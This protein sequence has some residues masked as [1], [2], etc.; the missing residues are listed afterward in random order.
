[1][2]EET[3]LLLQGKH[4]VETIMHA[5]SIS[6]Q[7]AINLVSK[8]KKEG[9]ATTSGGGRQKR[10]YTITPYRQVKQER[11]GTFD[12][13]NRY[14]KIKLVPQFRHVPHSK[15]REEDALID[16]V[17]TRSF[18]TV[19]ASL[20]LFRHIKDWSYLHKLAKESMLEAETGML[21]DIARKTILTKRMPEKMYKALLKKRPRKKRLLTQSESDDFKEISKKWN[22]WVPFSKK[23]ME[24]IK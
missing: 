20:A 13:I 9:Y 15:Y 6:M 7:A 23:D 11:P 21:Y 17:K 22:I 14:S 4:T 3:L 8:L 10:I 12:I 18:R 5:L 2:K 16:A 19:L 1:M 24:E